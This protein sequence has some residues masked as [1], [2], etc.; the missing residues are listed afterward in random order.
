MGHCGAGAAARARDHPR[1]PP[2]RRRSAPA[3]PGG[4][5]RVFQPR[6]IN[7]TEPRSGFF[8]D[9]MPRGLNARWVDLCLF[10]PAGDTAIDKMLIH[11][12]FFFPLSPPKFGVLLGKRFPCKLGPSCPVGITQSI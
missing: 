3:L 9:R 12:G 1:R 2:Q 8:I 11:L 5:R 4:Q 7:L 10:S 6:P